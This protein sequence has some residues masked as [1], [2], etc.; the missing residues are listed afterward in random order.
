MSDYGQHK[1]QRFKMKSWPYR[2][3]IEEL[4]QDRVQQNEEKFQL[5][6]DA[7]FYDPCYQSDDSGLLTTIKGAWNQ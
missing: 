5:K 4:I 7:G 3:V 2:S 1:R 6:S